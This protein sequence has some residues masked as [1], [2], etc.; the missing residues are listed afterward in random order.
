MVLD[1]CT[2]AAAASI[3]LSFAPFLLLLSLR[4]FGPIFFNIRWFRFLCLPSSI[5]NSFGSRTTGVDRCAVGS[6]TF[7]D[8][9]APFRTVFVDDR[10]GLWCWLCVSTLG[11]LGGC[12][13]K[14]I[15]TNLIMQSRTKNSVAFI[16]FILLRTMAVIFGTLATTEAAV[17]IDLRVVTDLG[18]VFSFRDGLECGLLL[19]KDEVSGVLAQEE[20]SSMTPQQGLLMLLLMLLFDDDS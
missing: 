20:G 14:K 16:R 8:D 11:I 19:L 17:D 7:C 9:N 15:V 4:A 5:S 10:S 1:P 6:S 13:V 3:F 18:C 2:C 12:S